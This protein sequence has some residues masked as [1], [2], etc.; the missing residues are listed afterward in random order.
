LLFRGGNAASIDIGVDGVLEELGDLADPG[1]IGVELALGVV[2]VDG[3]VVELPHGDGLIVAVVPGLVGA[4]LVLG[5]SGGVVE[6]PH[7]DGAGIVPVELGV[8]PD[9][10]VLEAP[11]G[12][13]VAEGGVARLEFRLGNGGMLKA[14]DVVGVFG[15]TDELGLPNGGKL[16]VVLDCT[17]G[18]GE[19]P[20][21]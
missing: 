4:G 5:I 21:I 6:L 7:G 3:G 8:M 18:L 2:S 17:E 14:D 12:D 13:E 1:A 15:V 11:H 16:G 9:G 19:E 20:G 10:G